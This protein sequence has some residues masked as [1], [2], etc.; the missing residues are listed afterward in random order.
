M[1]TEIVL[2]R[3]PITVPGGSGRLPAPYDQGAVVQFL[4]VVRGVEAGQLIA[5]LEYTAFEAMARH[6]F[7]II[8][9]HVGSRWPVSSIRLIHRLGWVAAG[10]PSL[11]V[12]VM[13]PHRAEAFAACEWLIAEM[14]RVVP[15]WKC[16][17]P[18]PSA[19][20]PPET[21]LDAS[22]HPA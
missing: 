18:A 12:E 10:E 9:C 1:R 8:L 17:R 11:W 7:S 15:I 4:G 2:T 5:G 13:A 22:Q 16:A 3:D 14:K 21:L 6:Q 20:I 19:E